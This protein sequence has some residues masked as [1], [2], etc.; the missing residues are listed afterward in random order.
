M[1][2]IK[3]IRELRGVSR[4]DLAAKIPITTAMLGYLEKGTRSLTEK[5]LIKISEILNCTK[6][7]ILGE[8]PLEGLE[9][10]KQD[11]EKKY[12]I[13]GDYIIASID[14]INEITDPEDLTKEGREELFSRV[15]KLIHDFHELPSGKEGFLNYIKTSLKQPNDKKTED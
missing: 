1:N 3:E 9:S 8:Q 11:F 5:Y 7:Q 6:A 10:A 15:Y 13:K 14:I 4:K 2:K 12:L